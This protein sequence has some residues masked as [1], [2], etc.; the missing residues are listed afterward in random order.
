[1][2]V[3]PETAYFPQFHISRSFPFDV[4]SKKL[5]ET[6]VHEVLLLADLRCQERFPS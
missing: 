4:C 5:C 3:A 2:Y 6:R 1:M